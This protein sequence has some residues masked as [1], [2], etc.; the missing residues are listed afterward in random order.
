MTHSLSLMMRL[1]EGTLQTL[2]EYLERLVVSLERRR[3]RKEG[4]EEE[5]D[6]FLI[7][8]LVVARSAP[9]GSL[10]FRSGAEDAKEREKDG[11]EEEEGE[12]EEGEEGF[13]K[14]IP[15]G[16]NVVD[17]G[18]VSGVLS[19]DMKTSAPNL[20]ETLVL[21]LQQSTASWLNQRARR[22]DLLCTRVCLFLVPSAK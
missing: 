20:S 6:G 12:E 11:G 21:A 14:S 13:S 1:F 3:R 15:Y 22:E 9:V 19:S 8:P 18:F 5:A 16:L 10:F 7:R 17:D 4:E 2:G